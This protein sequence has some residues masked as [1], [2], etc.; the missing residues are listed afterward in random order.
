MNPRLQPGQNKFLKQMH[1]PLNE[2]QFNNLGLTKKYLRHH[3]TCNRIFLG[4][5][6]STIVPANDA[7][8]K[9][10]TKRAYDQ[11]N[12]DGG[13]IANVEITSVGWV[14]IDCVVASS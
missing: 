10:T 6:A 11:E 9:P 4:T 12:R 14:A 7:V 2:K 13:D 3:F 1:R 5:F 8:S